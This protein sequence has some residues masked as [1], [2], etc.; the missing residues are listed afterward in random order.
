[1]AESPTTTEQY[2][3][4]YQGITAVAARCDGAQSSDGVGFNGQDT[5][6]GKRIASVP[7]TQWTD[8]V[9]VEAARIALTYKVQIL[10]YTGVDVSTLD[11]V[12]DANELGTNHLARDHARGYER[13]AQGADK[14]ALRSIDA[15]EG[16]L[17]LHYDK[18]DPDFGDLLAA[19][20]ALPGRTFDWDTKCNVA[21]VSD[22]MADFVLTWDFPLTED[23]KALLQAGP[24]VFYNVTLADNGDKVVIDTP[25]NPDL[26]DAVRNLQGRSWDGGLKVNTADVHPDVIEF[27][28]QWNLSIHPDA[29]A[30]CDKAQAALDAADAAALVE[31]DRRVVMAHVS[32]QKDPGALPPVFVDML[33]AVLPADVAEK[34]IAR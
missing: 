29:R 24:P 9:K 17:V 28:T 30:A 13:R 3:L 34:V 19:C 16:K 8:E 25:Y 1:M 12:R 10:E 23:A 4:V 27:V 2:E 22:E 21:P 5:K 31:D 7:F 26:V 6:F 15:Y 18:K 20:K 32:R 33:A 11:V 14:L